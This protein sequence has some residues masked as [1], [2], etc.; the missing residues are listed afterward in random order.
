[1]TDKM[2]HTGSVAMEKHTRRP[3]PAALKAALANVEKDL[4]GSM[5]ILK[6]A[7]G[8]WT[9]GSTNT[10]VGKDSVWMV[11]PFSFIH[12]FIAWGH[13]RPVQEVTAPM[14]EPLPKIGPPPPESLEDDDKGQAGKGWQRLSGF[15]LKC[16]S[17]TDKGTVA[18]FTSSSEG[19]RRAIK[20]LLKA[21]EDQ[22]GVD[23]FAY[24][25]VVKLDTDFYMHP[26]KSVGKVKTPEFSVVDW[27][28]L[29]EEGEDPEVA[30]DERT[31]P[32]PVPAA[33]PTAKRKKVAKPTPA[34]E[35]EVVPED[36][37]EYEDYEDYEEDP[38]P[39]LAPEP[40]PAPAPTARRRRRA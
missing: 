24:C 9:Y 32:E 28:E 33:V 6:F 2:T 17:G 30:E 5:T 34:P 35:P 12:G 27:T 39:E 3:A 36:E 11:D 8:D 37:D 40:D 29:P 31:A 15:A 22:L 4:V 13:G 1:M 7:K 21:I 38:E 10:D 16:I 19:G 18:R 23:E 14:T 20:A 25:P 26:D